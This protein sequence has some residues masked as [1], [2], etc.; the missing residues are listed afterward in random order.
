MRERDRQSVGCTARVAH[1]AQRIGAREVGRYLVARIAPAPG[2][3]Q[4]LVG[5]SERGREVSD[6]PRGLGEQHVIARQRALVAGEPVSEDGRGRVHSRRGAG[7][8]PQHD[9][10]QDPVRL[11][12]EPGR[13]QAAGELLGA[14]ELTPVHVRLRGPAQVMLAAGEHVAGEAKRDTPLVVAGAN[15]LLARRHRRWPR[16]PPQQHAA[17]GPRDDESDERDAEASERGAPT[18][19]S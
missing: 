16:E 4:R 13:E 2:E 7:S 3:P 14:I 8:A 10:A 18:G 17:G 19:P 6:L 1:P 12:A 11:A 5:G 15:C 9:E